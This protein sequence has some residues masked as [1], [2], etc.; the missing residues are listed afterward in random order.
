M[1]FSRQEYLEWVAISFS[2]GSSSPRDRTQVSC[3]TSL[4]SEPPGKPP[5]WY[6]KDFIKQGIQYTNTK[7][8]I[9]KFD[10]IK[11]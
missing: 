11:I 4:L 3:F 6:R 5:T 9:D 7:E 8:K 10:Y 1:E 2:R